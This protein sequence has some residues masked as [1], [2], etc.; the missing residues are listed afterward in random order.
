[1]RLASTGG[2][3]LTVAALDG[4]KYAPDRTTVSRKELAAAGRDAM[5][6]LLL[7]P[8]LRL[9]LA[10]L[11]GCWG[12]VMVSDRILVYPSNE[13]LCRRTGLS[14][15][16]VRYGIRG[17]VDLALITPKDSANGKRFAI[18][19]R[20]GS[21]VDVFGFD[22]TPVYARRAEFIVLISA[23]DA[24]NEAR[25]RL[26]D[27]VTICRRATEEVI[28]RL[29]SAQLRGAFE[30][31]IA[32]TPRRNLT[33]AEGVLRPLV[34]RWRSLRQLA[35]ETFYQAASGGKS[36][37][38]IETK[39]LN[40]KTEG[41][42]QEASQEA[43]RGE[44]P[45]PLSSNAPVELVVEACPSLSLFVEVPRT[46]VDL[47]AA[48]RYLRS[49]LGAHGTVWDEAVQALGPVNAAATVCLVLQLYNDDTASPE[50]KIRN[51]GGY[52]R[53]MVRMFKEGRSNVRYELM[54]LIRKLGG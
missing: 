11:I 36:C 43:G 52:L 20:A 33:L 1:M 2:R 46:E 40:L 53:A 7:R 42:E 6:G 22:L 12:E 48:G 27:E 13:Y 39:P 35:E 9:V 14:E 29:E 34:E 16:A 31:L 21:L 26:F 30:S 18:K 44:D 51:P 23:Q 4:A 8:S 49:S 41:L 10:E 24:E 54:A 28:A 32:D 19:N 37:Q 45:S 17:L 47:V 38:H 3:R 5:K 15:R 50:P 25:A